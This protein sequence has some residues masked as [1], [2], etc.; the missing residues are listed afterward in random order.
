[1]PA[2]YI[3]K[4]PLSPSQIL[5][6]EIPENL[7]TDLDNNKHNLILRKF[8]TVN[9]FSAN[10]NNPNPNLI[11]NML[12]ESTRGTSFRTIGPT[13]AGGDFSAT[14]IVPV[15]STPRSSFIVFDLG[16][17]IKPRKLVITLNH[18]TRFLNSSELDNNLIARGVRAIFSNT[19]GTNQSNGLDAVQTPFKDNSDFDV[20][21]VPAGAEKHRVVDGTTLEATILG[22]DESYDISRLTLDTDFFDSEAYDNRQFMT[23]E[24][25]G[26]R[27]SDTFDIADIQLW[28]EID[29]DQQRDYRVEFDDALLDQAGWKNIRY[30][31]SKLTGKKINEFNVG[32]ITYGKNPV[33]ESKT[34]AIYVVDTCIGAE[35]EDEQFAFISKHAY[36]NI[37]QILL[38]DKSTGNTVQIIDRNSVSN[39]SFQRFITSNLPVSTKFK[40]RIIDESIQHAL[41]QDYRIKF[42]RGFLL[43]SFEYDGS[44]PPKLGLDLNGSTSVTNFAKVDENA[45]PFTLYCSIE[46][47]IRDIFGFNNDSGGFE[48][49]LDQSHTIGVIGNGFR[50]NQRHN[51]GGNVGAQGVSSII[52]FRY[53]RDPLVKRYT[54]E[55][56]DNFPS[57]N[58]AKFGNDVFK[59]TFGGTI[60]QPLM[61]DTNTK[62]ISNKITNQF[63]KSTNDNSTKKASFDLPNE[64]NIVELFNRSQGFG[65][66]GDA[67]GETGAIRFFTTEQRASTNRLHPNQSSSLFI[68]NCLEFVNENQDLT[69][70]YLTLH[71]GQKDYSEINNISENNTLSIGTFEV[72]SNF[73]PP[74]IPADTGISIAGFPRLDLKLKND[75]R[76]RPPASQLIPQDQGLT[77]GTDVTVLMPVVT[78]GLAGSMLGVISVDFPIDGGGGKPYI[79]LQFSERAFIFEAG[80]GLKGSQ[81][82]SGDFSQT[83][84]SI[85][86]D[87]FGNVPNDANGNPSSGRQAQR[88]GGSN[89]G[90]YPNSDK[91]EYHIQ[92]SFLDKGPTL[93]A[94]VDKDK[95]LF[96]GIGEKG[97]LLIPENTDPDIKQN[98][99]FY[100]R[101]AGIVERRTVKAPERPE[102]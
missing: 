16:R 33:I 92:L 3:R 87:G 72:D 79:P 27:F 20:I 67:N 24:F 71:K 54:S 75:G 9:N 73:L 14:P 1:M 101:K 5:D 56:T 85:G 88:L 52:N 4:I 64:Q 45:N 82:A 17:K 12:D 47:S 49:N 90:N 86:T 43:K 58:D 48:G 81:I 40:V 83:V 93:I 89:T 21:T 38:I 70:L 22:D 7:F 53:H 51:T 84:N 41:K 10:P 61:M 96:D 59:F 91:N 18:G 65:T 30:D 6:A 13:G 94:D 39:D 29:I 34:S 78:T 28:E 97:L 62:L 55:Y 60:N 23:L 11:S 68:R 35:N 25:R 32:D 46:A 50:F 2:P 37:K 74:N 36:L 100:L 63:I 80:P 19:L 57:G 102:R 31:G 69:E 26:S 15:S 77:K 44:K 98:I 8:A 66:G 95:E 42:N 99:D 76:L